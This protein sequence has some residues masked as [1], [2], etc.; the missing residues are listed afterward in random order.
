MAN[1]PFSPPYDTPLP[2]PNPS[3]SAVILQSLSV[4]SVHNMSC[5]HLAPW[6]LPPCNVSCYILSPSPTVMSSPATSHDVSHYHPLHN[7]SYYRFMSSSPPPSP[8][9]VY[10]PASCT[11]I[12][13]VA[14][15][16]SDVS[17]CCLI[18]PSLPPPYYIAIF[19][20]AILCF[21]FFLT[22]FPIFSPC[23]LTAVQ[24]QQY[25]V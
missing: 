6:C 2:S 15:Y 9:K 4:L 17:P 5:L 14:T 25:T 23:H 18:L 24:K 11:A 7:I 13:C 22:Y 12:T 16:L 1:T 20:P 21:H 8:P 19:P 10:S 3:P